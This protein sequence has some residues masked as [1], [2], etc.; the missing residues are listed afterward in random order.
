MNAVLWSALLSPV[1]LL[2]VALLIG[3]VLRAADRVEDERRTAGRPTGATLPG[4]IPALPK[5]PV[6]QG[7]ARS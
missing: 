3:R 6:A 2:V 4:G 7:V 5:S 1:V